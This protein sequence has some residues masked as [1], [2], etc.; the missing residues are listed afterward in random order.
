MIQDV[1]GNK[2]SLPFLPPIHGDSKMAV[3]KLLWKGSSHALLPPF[4]E[5]H[6]KQSIP[7]AVKYKWKNKKI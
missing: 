5:T 6:L 4:I 7:L 1:A 3:E 2:P